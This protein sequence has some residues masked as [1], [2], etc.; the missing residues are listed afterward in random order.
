MQRPNAA[1]PPPAVAETATA[2]AAAPAARSV[3]DPADLPRNYLFV[4]AAGSHTYWTFCEALENT[5]SKDGPAIG[6]AGSQ[7]VDVLRGIEEQDGK[8]VQLSSGLALKITSPH[9][10]S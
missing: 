3:A 2:A 8:T 1:P 4:I 10:Q 6:K 9:K 7:N 5:T